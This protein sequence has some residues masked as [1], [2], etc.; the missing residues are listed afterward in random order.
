MLSVKE[1][2]TLAS[3]LKEKDFFKQLGPFVLI[4]RPPS[5]SA[6]DTDQMGLPINVQRT[7]VAKPEAMSSGALSLLFQFDELVVATLPPLQ[8]M[9][10]LS[11]GRQ[12]DCDLVLDDPSVS[13][14]HAVL[15]WDEKSQRCTIQDAGST[16]G[17]FL[18]ASIRLK[19]ETILKNGDILSFGEVQYWFLLTPTLWEKLTNLRARDVSV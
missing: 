17:T 10:E 12:P 6:T 4:Q 14:Q 3:R 15:R 5:K 9:D 2:R 18:N 1:L 11:V 8:G 16:N 7:A 13:K 19:K